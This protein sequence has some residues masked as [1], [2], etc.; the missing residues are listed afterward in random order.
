MRVLITGASGQLGKAL[1]KKGNNKLSLL[2]PQRKD[3]DL[4]NEESCR[5]FIKN[6]T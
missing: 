2:L 3:L 5:S 4:S 1:I 6:S